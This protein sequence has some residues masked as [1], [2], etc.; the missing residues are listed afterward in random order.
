MPDEV[1]VI[2]NNCSDKTIQIAKTYPFVTVIKEKTQGLIAARNTG[3]SR[4]KG[5]ILGR[6][7]ADS[8]IRPDWVETVQASFAAD[9]EL[10]GVSGLSLTYALPFKKGAKHTTISKA[11][12]YYIEADYRINVMWGANM[13][14]RKAAWDVVKKDV[15]LDDNAVHEDQDISAWFSNYALKVTRL[16]EMLISSEDDS[17]SYL[18]KFIEYDKRRVS[19]KKLHKGIGSIAKD[20]RTIHNPFKILF[21]L[22]TGNLFRLYFWAGGSIMLA[23]TR[24]HKK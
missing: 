22:T 2:D 9:Q 24:S 13:A 1:L 18:P 12:M 20:K 8:M 14:V 6:I 17:V 15:T 19:T 5:Q 11:Y 16:N 3:F 23:F 7:D 4:A 10:Q 21:G